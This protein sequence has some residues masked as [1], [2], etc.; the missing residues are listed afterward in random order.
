[1]RRGNAGVRRLFIRLGAAALVAAGTFGV[2]GLPR[3][4]VHQGYAPEQPIA[5]SH[6]LHAGASQIPCL[7]CHFNATRSRHAGIPP[8]SVC[9]NCHAMLSKRSR[10]IEK[11]LEAAQQRRPIAWVTV[12]ALPDFVY[13][14]HARH[15][16]A[17]V[18]CTACHGPVESMTRV[19]QEAPLTM[20]WCLDCHRQRVAWQENPH[21]RENGRLVAG[22]RSLECSSCHY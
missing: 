18:A 4:G 14:N 13:F 9:M 1:M 2:A 3:V 16:L 15:L 8:T 17:G 5:F 7:Y 10:E 12:H 21:G 11:L 22:S 6:Q 20:G 19:R